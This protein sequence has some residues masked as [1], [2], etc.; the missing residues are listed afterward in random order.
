[1]K[2]LLALALCLMLCGVLA[3]CGRAD[4]APAEVASE[5]PQ[6]AE[7]VVRL[8]ITAADSEFTAVLADN[9]T[10]QAFVRRLPLTLTMSEL[11]GNEKYHYLAEDLPTDPYLPGEIQAGDLLLYGE[12]CLVL[13]Y[14]N[15]E[16]GYR[17]TPLGQLETVDGL[18][19]AVGSGETVVTFAVL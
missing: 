12:D 18:A 15:L 17:Y 5:A 8:K 13:F 6:A 2:R 10:A 16:S 14:E 1:M 3:A 9:E 4:A 7:E 11:H 19:E